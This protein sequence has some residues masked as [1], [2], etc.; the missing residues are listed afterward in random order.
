VI[1]GD[2]FGGVRE[3]EGSSEE[4]VVRR[5]GKVVCLYAFICMIRWDL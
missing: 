2:V 5:M 4:Y 3:G 1:G